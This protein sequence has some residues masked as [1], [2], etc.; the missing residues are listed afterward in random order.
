MK[1]YIYIYINAKLYIYICVCVCV[2]VCV[3]KPLLKQTSSNELSS[4]V[5]DKAKCKQTKG[6]TKFIIIPELSY[7]AGA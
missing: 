5:S 1:L 3:C 2:C 7:D 6:N 4:M